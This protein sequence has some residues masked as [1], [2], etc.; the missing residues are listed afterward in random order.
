MGDGMGIS[1]LPRK[2]EWT[3]RDRN[4]KFEGKVKCEVDVDEIFEWGDY[5]K[6]IQLIES[7]DGKRLIR[8][9]YYVKD[10]GAPDKEYKFASQTT[11]VIHPENARKLF[12]DAENKRFFDTDMPEKQDAANKEHIKRSSSGNIK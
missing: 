2:V 9:A 11:L 1:H 8:F 5:K 10:H 4:H 7:K 12:I 6:L 3:E